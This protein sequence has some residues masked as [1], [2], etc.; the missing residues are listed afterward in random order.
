MLIPLI[1][2]I[3]VGTAPD[4][5]AGWRY[6]A[7]HQTDA[8]VVLQEGKVVFERGRTAGMT[9][10]PHL[11]A[12][13]SK[14]FCGVAAACL[15]KDGLLKSF[16]EKVSDT[17]Y[18]WRGDSGKA[19]I[20]YRQ[21]L[22]LSSGIETSSPGENVRCPTEAELLATPLMGDPGAKFAYGPRAFNLFS[23]AMERKLKGE[24]L[25]AFLD[26]RVF[27][28][29][30]IRVTWGNTNAEGRVQ[31]AGGARCSPLD[32]AKFGE[33]VRLG[34]K[35]DG[36]GVCDER[37]LAESG[38]PQGPGRAYGLSW[39][40][41]PEASPRNG[42]GPASSFKGFRAAAGMGK[43]L[44]MILPEIDTV[45]VRVGPLVSDFSGGEFLRA[46]FGR[47]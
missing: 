22:S 12:S 11:L 18:E 27:G 33:F 6:A 5:E 36:R 1:A 24:K 4:F 38:V 23:L 8:V 35:I 10:R 40:L 47:S 42:G 37:A 26:R 16:D 3:T 25:Q 9:S 17:L 19:A 39:W 31:F 45:V 46:I 32:W 20:T 30:G 41:S 28:P 2:A 34:G 14:T 7:A 44:M 21:L 29:L 43:Q 13:G 15:I